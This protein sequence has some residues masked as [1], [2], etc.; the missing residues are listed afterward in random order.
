MLILLLELKDKLLAHDELD[1]GRAI[2]T[3]LLPKEQ[4][5][6]SGWDIWL[7]TRPA[8]EV[9]GDLVDYIELG[10]DRFAVALGDVAGK[11]LGAALWMVKIQATLRALAPRFDALSKLAAELNAIL[12]RDGVRSRFASLFY[13]EL[14]PDSSELRTVNAGHLPPIVVTAEGIETKSRGAPA[15]GLMPGTTYEEERFAL[16]MGDLLLI[17]S[18]GVTEAMDGD[19]EFFGD[20]R[21]LKLAPQLRELPASE[22]GERVLA[23]VAAFVGDERPSDDLSLA[24]LKRRR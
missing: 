6:I 23:E 12:C 7:Y 8:K 13:L 22:A 18:D 19:R 16:A 2:Q 5:A 9:G 17:Y 11:R 20:D 4:P 24:I 1:A 14:K 21:L 10:D 3:A 15:L